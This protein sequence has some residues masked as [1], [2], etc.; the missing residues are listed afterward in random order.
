[1]VSTEELAKKLLCP[2]QFTRAGQTSLNRCVA[3]ECMAWFIEDI[4]EDGTSWGYC[5][6]IDK[7]ELDL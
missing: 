1:M 5:Q 2:F 6:L 4:K 3:S 7:H